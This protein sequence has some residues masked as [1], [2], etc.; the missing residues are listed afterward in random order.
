MRIRQKIAFISSLFVDNRFTSF[1]SQAVAQPR[2][3]QVPLV[4]PSQVKKAGADNS[5]TTCV[6]VNV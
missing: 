5:H 2:T 4:S 3:Q 6:D 1:E